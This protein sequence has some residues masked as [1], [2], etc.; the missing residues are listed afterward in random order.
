MTGSEPK[1]LLIALREL[2]N[3]SFYDPFLMLS[4]LSEKGIYSLT[5]H[6]FHVASKGLEYIW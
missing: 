3:L 6:R 1:P 5:C 2:V 4:K